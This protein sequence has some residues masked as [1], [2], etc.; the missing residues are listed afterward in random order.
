[1]MSIHVVL[2]ISTCHFEPEAAHR[3]IWISVKLPKRTK[4]TGN[5][6]LLPDFNLKWSIAATASNSRETSEMAISKNSLAT[7][8]MPRVGG[9]V[10]QARDV[11]VPRRG[12]R[13][14]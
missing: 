3:G 4:K 6:E 12:L 5:Q 10:A 7:L 11:L 9:L 2:C 14:Q 8:R 1:M 13:G